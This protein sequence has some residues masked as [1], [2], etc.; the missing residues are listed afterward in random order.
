MYIPDIPPPPLPPDSLPLIDSLVLEL[1]MRHASCPQTLTSKIHY[2][3]QFAVPI[4]QIKERGP[5]PSEVCT[6]QM[7]TLLGL[8]APLDLRPSVSEILAP[9]VRHTCARACSLLIPEHCRSGPNRNGAGMA[10]SN[11]C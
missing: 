2:H 9:S 8:E 4:C 5:W 7:L 3:A 1:N 6:W 10:D 11:H